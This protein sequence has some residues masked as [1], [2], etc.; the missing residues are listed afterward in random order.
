MFIDCTELSSQLLVSPIIATVG[1]KNVCLKNQTLHLS[2]VKLL[3]Y[4]MCSLLKNNKLM[5]L[6]NIEIQDWLTTNFLLTPVMV[7]DNT[8]VYLTSFRHL[9]GFWY[10][11]G[12]LKGWSIYQ[13]WCFVGLRT[14]F[15]FLKNVLGFLVRFMVLLKNLMSSSLCLHASFPPFL[16]LVKKVEE[17]SSEEMGGG[18]GIREKL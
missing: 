4:F 17:I 18:G 16:L 12:G 10:L 1:N 5:C 15:S 3:F 7:D 13:A 11:V 2:C 6:K 9:S 8:L 14:S